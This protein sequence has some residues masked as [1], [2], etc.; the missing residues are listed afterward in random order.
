MADYSEEASDSLFPFRKLPFVVTFFALSLIELVHCLHLSNNRL[1]LQ[2]DCEK[3]KKWENYIKS[4]PRHQIFS[5]FL[6]LQIPSEIFMLRDTPGKKSVG[7]LADPSENQTFFDKC[8]RFP[9]T[10]CLT[11]RFLNQSN[12]IAFPQP[13]ID[14]EFPTLSEISDRKT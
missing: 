4:Y 6:A 2:V 14:V 11:H 12:S 8:R 3:E 9:R 7:N 1:L 5:H 10:R 13:R